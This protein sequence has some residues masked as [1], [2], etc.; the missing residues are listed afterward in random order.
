MIKQFGKDNRKSDVFPSKGTGGFVSAAV[1]MSSV[2]GRNIAS[3]CLWES[4]G[5]M[6][7]VTLLLLGLYVVV[8]VQSLSRGWLFGTPWIAACQTSLSHTVSWSSPKCMSIES[9]M[10]LNHLILCCPFSFCLQ[11][12]P[13]SGYFFQWVGSSHLRAKVFSFSI[14]PSNE[15]SGLISFRID[16]FDLL[17]VQGT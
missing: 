5:W 7:S 14:N 4:V 15:Y 17:E 16:Y 3:S 12:F 10:L 6:K 13:V 1:L 11:S 8:V 9:V 2:S